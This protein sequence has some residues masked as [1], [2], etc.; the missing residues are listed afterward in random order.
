MAG[1]LPGRASARAVQRAMGERSRAPGLRHVPRRQ[2]GGAWPTA[3]PEDD[4][5][6]SRPGRAAAV[7][8][9]GCGVIRRYG[10]TAV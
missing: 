9:L 3:V 1:T 6:S 8:L 10:R 2:P 7:Y 4:G 5:R